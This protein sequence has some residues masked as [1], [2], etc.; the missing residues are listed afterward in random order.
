[1]SDEWEQKVIDYD[2]TDAIASLSDVKP[3]TK[4]ISLVAKMKHTH[5]DSLLRAF[6][7]LLED[8]GIQVRSS[9]FLT[10]LSSLT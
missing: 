3:D 4:I 2:L 10:I 1:M 9:T 6:A 8:E 7:A 5:D